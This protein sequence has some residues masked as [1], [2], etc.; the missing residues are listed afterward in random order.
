MGASVTALVANPLLALE[1]IHVRFG[2]TTALY[3]EDLNIAP[4][5]I[6]GLLGHNGAGKTTF[7]NVA[8]GAVRPHR[9]A[10]FMD[11]QRADILGNP[12]EID[13]AG[14]KVIHQEPALA[15]SLS[16]ADNICLERPD[17]WLRAT[18]RKERARGALKLVA[19]AIDVDRLASSLNFAERQAVSLARALSS[20]L[21]VLFLDE[22]TAALGQQETEQLHK[23]LQ[24]LAQQGK[25]IVYVSHRLRDALAICTRLVVLRD[26]RVVLNE[27]AQAFDSARL[28]EAL[29][30]GVGQAGKST[31]KAEEKI[32]LEVRHDT[33]SLQFRQGEIVGLFGMAAGPQFNLVAR[34]FGVGMP[35]EAR[36]DGEPYA[37]SGPRNAIKRGVYYV[38]ADRERDGL[39]GHMSTLENLALPWLKRYTTAGMYSRVK[40]AI[41][42]NQ[43]RLTLDIP[44]EHMDASILALS[45]GNR[46]KIVLG[47]WIFCDRPKVL[48]LSHPTQGIDVGARID[49]V[50]ALRELADAGATVLVSSSEAD[51]IELICDAAYTC[52]GDYW[53]RSEPTLGWSE[54]LLQSLIG[55][56]AANKGTPV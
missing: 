23:L 48:L 31:I 14:I 17:E 27:P 16:V 18:T 35:I 43:A 42:F 38:S 20:N 25:G 13:R 1:G 39:L 29:A 7:I 50:S 2:G 41:V 34:L 6:V 45:G 3:G 56:A 44:S 46:Q 15:D 10:L 37:P 49:I 54:K 12:G 55:Q 40:A 8:T 21:K 51:E 52:I 28:S 36:L 22:P 24:Q 9:G 5:E 4:G 26:G 11:G 33:Q 30:P 32:S 19:S 47:R 53:L